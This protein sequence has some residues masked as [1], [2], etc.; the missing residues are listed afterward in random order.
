MPLQERSASWQV[1]IVTGFESISGLWFQPIQKILVKMGSSSPR[2]G[3]NKKMFE[4]PPPRYELYTPPKTNMTI[5]KITYII[6][7][8]VDGSEIPFPTNLNW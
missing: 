5:G 6:L 1:F 7:N 8:T 3:M 4:L 2:L